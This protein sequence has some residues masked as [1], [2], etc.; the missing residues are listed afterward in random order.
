VHSRI[1]CG[2]AEHP[3]A[4]AITKYARSPHACTAP[5]AS[6]GEAAQHSNCERTHATVRH[7]PATQARDAPAGRADRRRRP[8]ARTRT[9][10]PLARLRE[11]A[12]R[13]RARRDRSRASVNRSAAQ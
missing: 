11:R 1:N 2:G 3:R 8:R 12:A 7:A 5:G 9:A 4:G 13:T 6:S 10:T